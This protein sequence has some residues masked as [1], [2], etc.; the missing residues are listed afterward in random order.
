MRE[1]VLCIIAALL[2]AG[3]VS[4]ACPKSTCAS[5][6]SSLPVFWLNTSTMNT[7]IH[8]PLVTF[9]ARQPNGEAYAPMPAGLSVDYL[10]EVILHRTFQNCS[11]HSAIGTPMRS[12]DQFQADS[13]IA[14]YM[15]ISEACCEVIHLTN[16]PVPG[17]PG[18]T[19][20]SY[21]VNITHPS[22]PDFYAQYIASTPSQSYSVPR[23]AT[24]EIGSGYNI[25][26]EYVPPHLFF[27]PL[28]HAFAR[29]CTLIDIHTFMIEFALL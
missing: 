6:D 27:F 13:R 29:L 8:G 28:N 7:R 19:T 1:L 20:E 14:R 18:V 12:F 5:W 21:L 9:Y 23:P 17:A 2:V 15:N 24:P 26:S 4:Q 10:G 11:S 22:Y 3:A 16:E 25:T